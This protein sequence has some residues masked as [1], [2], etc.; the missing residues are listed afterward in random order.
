MSTSFRFQI[1]RALKKIRNV[2]AVLVLLVSATATYLWQMPE[3][4]DQWQPVRVYD[5]DSFTLRRNNHTEE[6]RL[7]GIDC[8]EKHQ[9]W[10]SRARSFTS[11]KLANGNIRVEPV[12]KD[13]YGRTVAWVYT[14]SENLNRELLRNG[15]AWHYSYYA[16]DTSLERLQ[17]DARNAAKGL[18]SAADPEPPWE[19][20]RKNAYRATSTGN[21]TPV[22]PVTEPSLQQ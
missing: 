11:S 3:K 15:L 9:P 7:Y 19:Y 5:G 1:T 14:G 8:P 17:E 16:P 20:R 12:E 22:S 2:S 18:W 6:V 10:S 4:Y 13:R 21:R